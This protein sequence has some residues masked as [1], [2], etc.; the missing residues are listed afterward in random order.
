MVMMPSMFC[1]TLLLPFLSLAVSAPLAL[2]QS[3]ETMYDFD[4]Y[5]ETWSP[6]VRTQMALREG[7]QSQCLN[8][9]ELSVHE[10]SGGDSGAFVRE[11]SAQGIRGI[12]GCIKVPASEGLGPTRA[13]EA[14]KLKR[15][16]HSPHLYFGYEIPGGVNIEAGLMFQSGKPGVKEPSYVVYVKSQ[17]SDHRPNPVNR[18]FVE[19][20]E[21]QFTFPTENQNFISSNPNL[22][23]HRFAPGDLICMSLTYE[24]DEGMNGITLKLTVDPQKTL[25][26]AKIKGQKKQ[27][28]WAEYMNRESLI[29]SGK[30]VT[31]AEIA[32]ASTLAN[33][34][35]LLESRKNGFFYFDPLSVRVRRLT[36]I[37]TAAILENG[38]V[39]QRSYRGDNLGSCDYTA[40][41]TNTMVQSAATGTWAA[42]GSPSTYDFFGNRCNGSVNW[43]ARVTE[44]AP[45]M[46]LKKQRLQTRAIKTGK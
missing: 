22:G 32:R 24:Q 19:Q 20:S 41:W 4:R 44:I 26:W 6:G 1:R 8:N 27:V 25:R 45:D 34:Y 35:D 16:I 33:F 23:I 21:K 39:D 46:I 31:P 38:A 9:P 10:V 30:P 40:A 17:N 3:T 12:R 18:K 2:A 7:R 28:T 13:E 5:E 36:A 37:A 11:T 43:P 42:F 14:R 15:L 29:K